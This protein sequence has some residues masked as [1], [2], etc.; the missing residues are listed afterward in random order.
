MTPI[1]RRKLVNGL[2]NKEFRLIKEKMTHAWYGL[3]IDNEFV[4]EIKTFVSHGSNQAVIGI[5]ILK[6]IVNQL[7]MDD[8]H[9]L[10]DFIDCPYTYDA[11]IESLR[12]RGIISS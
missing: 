10:R 2:L 8:I 3:T 7:Q 9:Q 11:Y 6:K 5:S 4:P 1:K 12:A